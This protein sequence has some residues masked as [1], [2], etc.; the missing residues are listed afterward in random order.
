[1]NR[2]S[3]DDFFSQVSS[4]QFGACNQQ[5]MEE[6]IKAREP[7]IKHRNLTHHAIESLVSPRQFHGNDHEWRERPPNALSTIAKLLAGR[8][9][10]QKFSI[11]FVATHQMHHSRQPTL[12]LCHL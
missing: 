12:L 5:T 7:T 9:Q 10:E 11:N 4:C 8:R 2:K 1:M 3:V 6:T